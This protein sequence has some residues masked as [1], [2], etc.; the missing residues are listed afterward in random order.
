M[1]LVSKVIKNM[2]QF[3]FQK[4]KGSFFLFIALLFFQFSYS[5]LTNFTLQVTSTNETCSGNGSLTFAISGTTNGATIVYSIFLLPNSTSPIATLSG[6]T[7]GGLVAG[8]YSVIATQSLGTLTNSQQQYVTIINQISTLTYAIDG[9]NLSCGVDG[10]ITINTLT[11][12][13][14]SYE[15][16]SGPITFPIQ[17]S[18][19][20]VGLILGSYQIRVFDNCGDGIVQTFSVF[21]PISGGLSI[22]SNNTFSSSNCST[23]L[24]SQTIANTDSYP[25]SYPLNIQYTVFHPVTGAA[26]VS[27][28]D[29]KSVV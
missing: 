17:S 8:N 12:N 26:I 14:V 1:Y 22:T 28:Q 10:T 23:V 19:I 7:I 15:I 29:R 25:I 3:N 6:N 13:S 5:Q 4:S 20:F 24:V 2:S 9:N 21:N 11:G 18:N 16:F 27:N